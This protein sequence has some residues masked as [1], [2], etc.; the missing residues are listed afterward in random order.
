MS[1]HPPDLFDDPY[2]KVGQNLVGMV[3]LHLGQVRGVPADVR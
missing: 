2:Q 1:Y 3:K